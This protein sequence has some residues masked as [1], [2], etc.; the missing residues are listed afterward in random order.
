MGPRRQWETE[1]IP[2][3]VD[4]SGY[5]LG[6]IHHASTLQICMPTHLYLPATISLLKRFPE[7]QGVGAHL[8]WFYASL[9]LAEAATLLPSLLSLKKLA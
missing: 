5:T 4:S 8:F 3:M 9:N 7:L 1:I 2:K 6:L